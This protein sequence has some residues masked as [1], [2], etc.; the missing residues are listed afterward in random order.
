MAIKP[1]PKGQ[2]ELRF[3]VYKAKQ[4]PLASLRVFY[5]A[6]EEWKPGK[7]GLTLKKKEIGPFVKRL[8]EL[9]DL[10]PDEEE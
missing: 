3:E 5:M 10:L 7:Q 4:G 6:G 9:Y 2:D 1:M 8:K